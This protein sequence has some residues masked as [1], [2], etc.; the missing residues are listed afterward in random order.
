[1]VSWIMVEGSE[2]ISHFANFFLISIFFVFGN[3]CFFITIYSAVIRWDTVYKEMGHKWASLTFPLV[4]YSRSALLF[5][6]CVM[7][8]N[9]R[10]HCEPVKPANLTVI[11][12]LNKFVFVWSSVL[13][14]LLLPLVAHI[15]IA[16]SLHLLVVIKSNFNHVHEQSNKDRATETRTDD[17]KNIISHYLEI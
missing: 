4:A 16:G 13:C 14:A 15:I 1:M 17:S 5:S 9:T 12:S 2:W 11:D 6:Q 10:I 3:I 8:D 7:K